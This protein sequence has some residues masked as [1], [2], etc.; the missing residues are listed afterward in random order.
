MEIAPQT[1]LECP[2]SFV[3]PSDREAGWLNYL[4]GWTGM[5]LD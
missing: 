5:E 4:F 2:W 3:D 1:C